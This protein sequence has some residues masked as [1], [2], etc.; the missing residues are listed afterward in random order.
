MRRPS[1][2]GL[3]GIGQICAWGTLYYSFP[4]LSAAMGAEFDWSGAQLYGALTVGLVLSGVASYPVGRAIDRGHGR[5]LMTS[6]ALAAALLL[7]AWSRVTSL[8]G[9][10]LVVAM[11]GAVQAATLYEAAFAVVGR[12]VGPENAR[13][14]ITHL[15]LWGGFA[16]TVFVPLV[17]WLLQS[18]GW[19]P[20]LLVLAAINLL[21]CAPLHALLI[22]PTLDRANTVSPVPGSTSDGDEA[23]F[24]PFASPTFWW[25][26]LCFVAHAG[27]MSAF[28]FHLYP[29][30]LERGL[31]TAGVV[32]VIAVIG[33]AQVAGRM[34]VAAMAAR[35]SIGSLGGVTV[36]G[37]LAGFAALALVPAT[38][39]AML[40]FSA[41][42]GAANGVL[43]IVRGLIVPELLTRRGYG[44]INGLI[45]A[46]SHLA[47]ALA[48][49][50]AAFLW[51]RSGSYQAV[52]AALVGGAL[53]MSAAYWFALQMRPGMQRAP[54]R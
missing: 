13:A 36:V 23:D 50:A 25:I 2:V 49:I 5:W 21:V 24:R 16:S 43:T 35:A 6:A 14:G 41:A 28:V 15:T 38:L 30:L 27:V 51:D 7:A 37:L 31:D 52:M 12:R 29:L 33:P 40:L 46:P 39:P 10:Y 4:Q 44:A 26:S 19:R 42:I 32:S 3:L 53:L 47:R 18:W 48:P 54:A 9:F 1:F 22:R 34:A 11:L 17:E 45:A 20:A 8:T